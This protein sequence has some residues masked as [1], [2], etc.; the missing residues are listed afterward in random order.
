VKEVNVSGE[1]WKPENFTKVENG[2][3]VT[4]TYH[5]PMT[6]ADSYKAWSPSGLLDNLKF[7]VTFQLWRYIGSDS[8]A[9][10]LVEPEMNI[11]LD[12]TVDAPCDAPCGY[13]IAPWQVHW[14]GIPET[15][16]NGNDY[17]Y[18]VKETSDL[19]P[20]FTKSGELTDTI[21]NHY[22][23]M[24][25]EVTEDVVATK[26]WK[27]DG[28]LDSMKFPVTYQLYRYT[29][30]P[31][32]PET[33]GDS[34]TLNAPSWS[35]T[36]A[37]MP[38]TD[39]VGNLYTYYVI[40]TNDLPDGFSKVEDG[41]NVTN[42][43]DNMDDDVTA[44]VT[45]TKNWMPVGLLDS[46][47]VPVTFQLYRYTTDPAS[48]ET[49][50]DPVELNAAGGWV[51]TWA[52][53]PTTDTVGN[54]YTYYVEETVTPTG[55]DK[56]ED[57]LTVTNTYIVPSNAV[58]AEKEWVGG[59]TPRPNVWFQLWRT[60]THEGTTYREIVPGADIQML[61]DGTFSVFWSDIDMETI[62]GIPYTFYVKEV[63]ANGFDFVPEN[64]AKLED[65]LTVTNTYVP[66]LMI[67]PLY[68]NKVWQGGKAPYPAIYIHLYRN[69]PGGSPEPVGAP[70]PLDGV[71]DPGCVSSCEISP[72]RWVVRDLPLTDFNGNPYTY[73]VR[74]T[75]ASGNDY[76]PENYV[77]SIVDLTVTNT[78]HSPKINI[79]MRK[80][81][82]GG[83][84]PRPNIRI[85]LYRD[86]E[87]YGETVRLYY[88]NT[89]YTWKDLDKTDPDGV[90]YV[91]TVDELALPAGY[92]KKVSGLTITNT[93]GD[94]PYT[95][96]ANS[97]LL[98][99]VLAISS[100]V[101][102]GATVAGKRRKKK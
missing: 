93:Y 50:G 35:Y 81:W 15:D 97:A 2:L 90:D 67:D 31:D 34:V 91:Y 83:P 28:L 26:T 21:T 53:M 58:V 100:L 46:L 14:I 86:G 99:G 54:P 84:E 37:D 4:N 8:S 36:W 38:T 43:Y 30:D 73:T 85:Q 59:P 45:A 78:Y 12:G 41:L 70:F 95:G 76:T 39:T 9:A 57:G 75:D 6:T 22:N 40:E 18:V 69:I 64:Y 10:T 1:D 20:G 3:T 74:E 89:T 60:W 88:P 61:A 101:G 25:D 80:I 96:D 33:V 24:D 52:D 56:T 79:T 23:N 63:D 27:P 48:P 51:Y 29:T 98:Y 68:I 65:G 47:K 92:T 44:D 16:I 82:I 102:F 11:V 77:K 5:S 19:N 66:P 7:N 55:F 49:V 42:T 94:V 13:E 17:H 71:A 32:N 72:W 62:I 87:P